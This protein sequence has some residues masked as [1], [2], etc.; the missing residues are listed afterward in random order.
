MS[1]SK[2]T[3]AVTNKIPDAG[4]KLFQDKFELKIG[5]TDRTLKAAE[6]LSFVK[7]A[8]AILPLLGNKIDGRVMDAAGKQLK[9]VANYAVGY[10]NIDLAAAKKRKVIVT[11]T[12]GVL[13]E[14]VAEHAF[15]LLTAVARRIVESDK[16]LRAGKYK[17]WM[18]ELL[19]GPQLQGKTLGI[20]GLGR[21]GSRVA[22]IGA[23]GY[24]MKV[25]YFDRG[26]KDRELDKKIGA[27]AA[28][29]RK[30]LTASDFISLHVPL[31]PQTRHLIG[32]VE[33]AT[34]KK[35]AILINTSRGPVVDE[36]ALAAA[37][38]HKVIWGAGLDVFEFEPQFTPALKKL[39]NVVMTP[40]TASATHE[41]RDEMAILA[42]K[43]IISVLAGQ[44]PLTEVK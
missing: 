11:N 41:A 19:L 8:A 43:N 27:E 2:S 38:Q 28:S 25:I 12:P 26:K 31:T 44:A 36:V 20:I 10:D 24:G 6:L 33:L 37:L 14:A 30:I 9:I 18:P 5:P 3:V 16:F 42:A 34:M 1:Q 32:R 35:S 4:I 7:G 23:L 40:H 29:L 21:I 15:T 22:E 13:T 39:D 17:S